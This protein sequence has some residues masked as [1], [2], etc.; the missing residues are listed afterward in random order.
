MEGEPQPVGRGASREA[1]GLVRGVDCGCD[2]E[3]FVVRVDIAM[4]AGRGGSA[5][6]SR[7][8]DT[9]FAPSLLSSIA[10]RRIRRVIR[11]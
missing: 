10:F 11:F 5:G 9:C 1:R 6:T 2:R 7:R 3:S 4:E 8:R